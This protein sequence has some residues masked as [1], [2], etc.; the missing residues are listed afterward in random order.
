LTEQNIGFD[1]NGNLDTAALLAFVGTGALDN[2]FVTTWYDQSGNARNATQTT[3]ISQPQIVSAGSL[4]NKY[5]KPNIVLTSDFF[6]LSSSIVLNNELA[7][8]IVMNSSATGGANAGFINY[9]SN[10][11]DD[12]ELRLGTGNTIFDYYNGGYT[13]NGNDIQAITGGLFYYERVTGY[14]SNI[15][16]NNS[17]IATGTRA[18]AL[19]SGVSKFTIGEYVSTTRDGNISEL[20]IYPSNQSSN[21]LGMQSNINSYYGIY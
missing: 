2:G 15:Y 20:I 5:G 13:L 4:Q 14:T 6:N 3:A 12:A 7:M 11:A 10:P 9:Q 8:L 18:G 17:F 19:A 1:A 21:R 16:R